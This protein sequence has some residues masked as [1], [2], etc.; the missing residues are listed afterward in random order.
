MKILW[1]SPSFLHPTTRGGQIR[2]LQM[3]SH[4]HRWHEIHYVAF[5]RPGEPEGL[6]RSSEYSSRAY[7]IPHDVPA[8]GSPRFLLQASRN[9]FSAM[10]LAVARYRSSKMR[11]QIDELIA[12]QEFD[13]IV[14]DF[15][16]VAPNVRPLHRSVLFE[17]N[18]ETNIWQRHRENASN[19][20]IRAFFSIQAKRMFEYERAV[21]RQS[22]HVIAVSATDASRFREMFGISRVSSVP[23]GVDVDYFK[24]GLAA[25]V[26]AADLVF[27]GSM[28]WLPNV[29]GILYFSREILPLIR[30][31]K[32][33]CT[34]AVV[35]RNPAREIV[36]MANGD[37]GVRVSGTVA[38]IRPYFWN[39]SVSIVP[40][41]VGGGTRLKI[42]EAMAAGIP[43]VSTSIGA[44]GLPVSSGEDCYIADSPRDF[45][46]RCLELLGD[47]LLRSQVAS[48]GLQ[49]VS[50]RCSWEGA[51][52]C[53]EQIL[54]EAP[55][56][57]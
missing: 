34:L 32:P 51:S 29:E 55:S 18:V 12:T 33:D 4:L 10:P 47:S 38:D 24:P 3:L 39:S 23:T 7:A 43:V 46:D 35:G 13:R 14:C 21:C 16:F 53:F 5:E 2:T 11:Q 41:R 17:H 9:L 54:H 36:E 22:A 25:D 26:P 8:R 42:L 37:S 15:L 48:A 56:P 27:V 49:L 40:L 30:Q 52:R 6:R 44:E 1:V 31:R 57:V 50:S 20:L 28:D 45:A 19:P